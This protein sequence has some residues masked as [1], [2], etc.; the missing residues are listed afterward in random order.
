MHFCDAH[1]R[2]RFLHLPSIK[3]FL[4]SFLP[5]L[6]RFP[7]L[8]SPP[9][10]S[11]SFRWAAEVSNNIMMWISTSSRW[12]QRRQSDLKTG[13]RGLGSGYEN[14]KVVGTNGS[15]DGG[16]QHR[17]EGIIPRIFYLIMHK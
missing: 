9:R 13:G 2:L 11:H 6:L 1:C 10:A 5:S 4:H 3:L 14:W 16:T 7:G 15:T 8:S 17:I 12:T